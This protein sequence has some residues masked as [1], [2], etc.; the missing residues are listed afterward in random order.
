MKIDVS[1]VL[2]AIGN[3]IKIEE[4][5]K[6][7]FPQDDLTLSKP[8]KVKLNL[9]NT[10]RTL[11]LRGN[12]KT[13]V[14]LSCCRCL[15]EF[16]CPISIDIEEEFS[17]K[18]TKTKSGGKKSSGKKI[19]E[20]EL[21]EEDFIFKIDNDNTI[22]L[23][24]TIRQNLLTSLPIKPLC[25]KNCKGLVGEKQKQK[26]VDPRLAKLKDFLK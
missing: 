25:S 1:E 11:L 3:E 8:V 7:S 14:R 5:E 13:A 2:K 9:V 4:S 16:D 24:E 18:A 15:K 20:V 22:D 23:S 17:R 12:I 21:K 10:G 19:D 6:I 26:K